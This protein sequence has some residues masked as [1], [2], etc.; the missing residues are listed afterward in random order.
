MTDLSAVVGI[1]WWQVVGGL[2]TLTGFALFWRG[3]FGGAGG[4]QGL[5]RRRTGTLGRI[6]G[7]RL[8]VLGLAMAGGGL[9]WLFAAR[10]LL[11]LSLGIGICEV[12]EAS[13]VISAWKAGSVRQ[14]RS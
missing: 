1:A 5:L 6:E 2:L 12:Q 10:W 9:A 14:S 13:V 3:L 11:F 8:T 7:W 4:R